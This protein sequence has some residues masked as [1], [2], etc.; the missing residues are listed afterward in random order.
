MNALEVAGMNVALHCGDRRWAIANRGIDF[1]LPTGKRCALIGESGSGKSILV[2]AA[3]GYIVDSPS[4]AVTATTRTLLG[5]DLSKIKSSDL[6]RLRRRKIVYVPQ[7][8][9][10]ALDPLYTAEEIIFSRAR[11][12]REEPGRLPVRSTRNTLE[13]EYRELSARSLVL[14]RSPADNYKRSSWMPV[15]SYSGGMRQLTFLAQ[16]ILSKPSL[17]IIDEGTTA[18]DNIKERSFFSTLMERLW[19]PSEQSAGGM[20]LLFISHDINLAW[21]YADYIYVMYAGVMVE[22]GPAREVIAEPKHPYTRLLLCSRYSLPAPLFSLNAIDVPP[23][24]RV[25]VDGRKELEG[26]FGHAVCPFVDRCPQGGPSC[27]R[28]PMPVMRQL[29]GCDR[30]VRCHQ[31]LEGR[32]VVPLAETNGNSSAAEPLLEVEDIDVSAEDRRIIRSANIAVRRGESLGLVGGSG[33]G[34]STLVKALLRLP[35]YSIVNGS[36]GVRFNGCALPDVPI[37]RLRSTMQYV[38]QIVHDA[39]LSSFSVAEVLLEPLF[40][41]RMDF[42]ESIP[43]MQK[44]VTAAL[45]EVGLPSSLGGHDAMIAHLSG[46][47][48]QRIAIAR[49]L[50]ALRFYSDTGDKQPKLLILDEPTSSLDVTVKAGILALLRTLQDRYSLSFLFVSHDLDIIKKFCSRIAVMYA[51]TIVEDTAASGLA[52]EK[53]YLHPYTRELFGLWKSKREPLPDPVP[54]FSSLPA[55]C[56]YESVCPFKKSVCAEKRPLLEIQAHDHRIACL[57]GGVDAFAKPQK[58]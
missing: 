17:I 35:R 46:G 28:E 56:V 49:A 43:S 8:N 53:A 44:V 6:Q 13:Q 54:D 26:R 1:S 22:S 38:P 9:M 23:D 21:N 57:V 31:P 41:D 51:G 50:V 37:K 32:I 2:K 58:L 18:L 19:N 45:S 20:S 34:K 33:H 55:G 25:Q 36:G 52:D 12:A 48:K 3:L 5:Y 11:I 7:E 27:S 39:F 42:R 4:T 15:G 24:N 29:N 16:A 47:Q 10:A 14:T 40:A 30:S